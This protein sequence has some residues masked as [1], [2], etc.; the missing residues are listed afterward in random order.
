[1]VDYR[2]RFT[3]EE[4]ADELQKHL[5]KCPPGFLQA[6][7]KLA[8]HVQAKSEKYMEALAALDRAA[9]KMRTVAATHPDAQ[10]RQDADAA[11]KEIDTAIS[12]Y[13]EA[14]MMFNHDW[15]DQ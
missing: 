1:M 11:V 7:D 8:N 4:F 14:S 3:K 15:V 5:E 6:K 9:E 13:G 2:K 10:A 12:A